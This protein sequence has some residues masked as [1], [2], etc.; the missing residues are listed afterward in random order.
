[1]LERKQ[2]QQK[3]RTEEKKQQM[4][5]QRKK[6]DKQEK[7]KQILENIFDLL[8]SCF[9]PNHKSH[10]IINKNTVK[11]IYSCTPNIKQIINSHNKR[12]INETPKKVSTTKL[13][14]CRNKPSLPLQEKCLEKS[15]VYQK[16]F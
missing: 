3:I 14:N 7:E 5:K 12:I 4:R 8:N 1:M 15:L 6:D 10:K 2:T 16:P 13:C 11:L 9:P